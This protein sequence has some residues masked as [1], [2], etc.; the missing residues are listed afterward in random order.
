MRHLVRKLEATALE[1]TGQ[2]RVGSDSVNVVSDGPGRRCLLNGYDVVSGDPGESFATVVSDLVGKMFRGGKPRTVVVLR[3]PSEDQMQT[4]IE[5]LRKDLGEGKVTVKGLRDGG[6]K[7]VE[8]ADLKLDEAMNMEALAHNVGVLAERVSAAAK[9]VSG[10]KDAS[11]MLTRKRLV[12]SMWGAAEMQGI[13]DGVRERM[14][15]EKFPWAAVEGSNDMLSKS[16]QRLRRKLSSDDPEDGRMMASVLIPG[17]SDSYGTVKEMASE[18]AVSVAPLVYID[19]AFHRAT[20]YPA[21]WFLSEEV[22]DKLAGN[23]NELIGFMEQIPRIEAKVID[24]LSFVRMR[25]IDRA[26]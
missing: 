3:G 22:M 21:S 18:A 26:K 13:L 20:R 5:R 1:V 16:A 14:D 2:I 9:A 4:V 25:I 24:P 12:E 17:V 8:P 6:R 15:G 11:M 10:A 7:V 23:Y 19:D